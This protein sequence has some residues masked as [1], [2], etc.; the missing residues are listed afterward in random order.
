MMSELR[1]REGVQEIRTSVIRVST[2]NLDMGERGVQNQA[3]NSDIT[4]GWS[5]TGNTEFSYKQVHISELYGKKY[6]HFFPHT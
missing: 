3:E 5:Q 1:G 4:Y 6:H 2:Q